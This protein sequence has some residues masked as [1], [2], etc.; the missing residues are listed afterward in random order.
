MEPVDNSCWEKI[1]GCG[2][3]GT[4]EHTKHTLASAH[5]SELLYGILN[6]CGRSGLSPVRSCGC[7]LLAGEIGKRAG[8]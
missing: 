1:E 5:I 8:I 6:C 7:C 2:G 4:P 3:K